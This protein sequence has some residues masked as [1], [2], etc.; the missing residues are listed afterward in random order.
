[1]LGPSSCASDKCADLC[2]PHPTDDLGGTYSCACETG[3]KLLPDKTT[4]AKGRL[5]VGS[6]V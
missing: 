6:Y 2:L 4:C 1:M 5:N 3:F